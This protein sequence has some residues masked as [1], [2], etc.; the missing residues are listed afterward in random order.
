[1][2]REFYLRMSEASVGDVLETPS[3]RKVRVEERLTCGSCVLGASHKRKEQRK[4]WGMACVDCACVAP[5]RKDR[6]T[7]VLVDA[8]DRRWGRDGK[9]RKERGR[10][11]SRGRVLRVM[12]ILFNRLILILWMI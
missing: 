4:M 12:R 2:N 3:G 10:G 8:E 5:A 7:V 9:A 11:T 1:M 6:K